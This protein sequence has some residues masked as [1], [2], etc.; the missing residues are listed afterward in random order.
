MLANRFDNLSTDELRERE[1]EARAEAA[2]ITDALKARLLSECPIRVGM[3][4]RVNGDMP[5]AG[6]EF[7]VCSRR[8][9]NFGY[10]ETRYAVGIHGFLSNKY[11]TTRDGF[12]RRVSI[13]RDWTVLD[14]ASERVGPRIFYDEQSPPQKP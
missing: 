3:A 10:T 9:E 12:G 14:L 8:T 1:K 4:Y 6:K 5:S 2:V 13:I 7:L 11:S